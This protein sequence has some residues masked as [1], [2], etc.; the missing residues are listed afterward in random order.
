V[1]FDVA[2]EQLARE[3]GDIIDTLRVEPGWE[4]GVLLS[5]V[6]VGDHLGRSSADDITLFKSVGNASQDLLSAMHLVQ[7]ARRQGIGTEVDELTTLKLM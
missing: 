3:S 7:E 1:V 6:L 5:E 4:G 2:L